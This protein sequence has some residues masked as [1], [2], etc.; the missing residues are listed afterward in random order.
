M[1]VLIVGSGGR[2]HAIAWKCAKSKKVDT[3]FV[4]PGNPGMEDVA[5]PIQLQNIEELIRFVKDE[6]IQL[7][8]I[9]PEQPLAEGMVDEF[10]KEDIVVIGPSKLAAEIEGSKVFAK[11]FMKKYHIPTAEFKVFDE[12]VPALNYILGKEFP[13]VLKADGLAAGKGVFICNN[14]TEAETI[15]NQ[16]MH[17]G[18]FGDAGSRV[19]IEECLQ[20]EEVSLFAFTDGKHFVSTILSQ[21]HKQLLDGDKGP[22]TGGMGAYAPAR[23]TKDLKKQ[24][25]EEIIAPTLKGMHKEGRTFRGILYAGVMLTE[26]GPQVLEFNCRLG[27]PETQV[28]LPLL[29]NDLID[30]C[31]AI[32]NERID[33]VVLKWKNKSAVNVVI[34][35]SGYPGTYEKGY[36]I[37][38]LDKVSDGT[39]IF[40]AGVK[41]EK[42]TLLTNGGRVLSLTAL[43]NDLQDAQKQVYKEVEKVSFTNSYYRTDIAQKG[44]HRL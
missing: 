39:L 3:V 10:M 13:L 37:K 5:Q 16:T 23:F 2:E 30:V 4:A 42:D 32:L 7:T 11:N 19:V 38:G 43:G 44:I 8:I 20:G 31:E 29:D 33:E 14:Y 25:D 41:K 24:V 9:G 26:K 27:D 12:I 36:P 40:F 21:D 34:A 6:G 18:L 22:N 1:K 28:I 35:S 17:Y 15:L